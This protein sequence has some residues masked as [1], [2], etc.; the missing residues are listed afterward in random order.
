[1]SKLEILSE[2]VT[3]VSILVKTDCEDVMSKRENFIAFLN[4]VGVRNEHGRELNAVSFKKMVD[5][6][7]LEEKKQLI[8]EF[9]EGFEDIYRYLEMFSK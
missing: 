7:S 3:I 4:E 5:S 2:I 6:L 9:N 8:E 1:M